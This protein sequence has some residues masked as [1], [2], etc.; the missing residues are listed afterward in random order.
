M[1]RPTLSRAVRRL[2]RA[3]ML[4]LHASGTLFSRDIWEAQYKN[5][6]WD[7]LGS[8]DDIA[9]YMVI[10]AYVH[11]INDSPSILEVGCGTGILLKLLARFGFKRYHG[12]DIS[13]EAIGAAASPRIENAS[14]EV[15]DFEQ[16]RPPPNQFD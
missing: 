16:W 13:A 7:R 6:H 3:L 2:Y 1:R 8:I 5:G 11:R 15:A 10:A 14:L 4:Q 12:I 9:H